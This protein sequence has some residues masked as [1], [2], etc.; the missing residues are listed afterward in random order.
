M[1]FAGNTEPQYIVP[2]GLKFIEVYWCLLISIEVTNE[3][4]WNE[5]GHVHA[6][7]PRAQIAW[8]IYRM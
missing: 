2:T 3:M 5:N 4:K 6:N 1:G 7:I 8:L